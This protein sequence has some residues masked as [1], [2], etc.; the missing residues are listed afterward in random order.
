MLSSKA[1]ILACNIIGKLVRLR[2]AEVVQGLLVCPCKFGF[3]SSKT[4]NEPCI[5]IDCESV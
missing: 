5:M 2:E 3:R 1:M 4:V